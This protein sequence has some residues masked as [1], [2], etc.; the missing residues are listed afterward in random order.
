MSAHAHDPNLVSDGAAESH[1][2]E[3]EFR[4]FVKAIASSTG[5]RIGLAIVAVNVV[6]FIIGPLVAPHDPT[7]TL[8]GPI[9]QGATS[10]NWFGTDALGRDVV[11]RT[12][13]GG[14]SVILPPLIA[15][16]LAFLVGGSVGMLIGYVG[17]TADQ[18]VSRFLDVALAI[19]GILLALIAIA[20]FGTSML[21]LILTVAII[22]T[23][24][25]AVVLR[26]SVR[27]VRNREYVLAAE[28]R[29]ERPVGVVAR[30]ILPNVTGPMLVEFAIRLTYAVIFVV[31]L[32]VLGLGVQP[33]EANWGL[34]VSESRQVLVQAPVVGIAPALAIAQLL[35][36]I[37]LITDAAAT[38]F[39]REAT[40]R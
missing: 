15:V 40:Q 29:G 31:S 30:E 7:E 34:M 32:S 14:G 38:Y 4:T 36:G 5:G 8:V 10:E 26:G 6:F 11:S 19:P 23:P 39:H 27:A 9:G 28:A 35:V 18:V 20:A 1:A 25:V 2:P 33:P 22:F 3:G 12:L 24:R 16:V 13:A 17:G 37:I 21:V